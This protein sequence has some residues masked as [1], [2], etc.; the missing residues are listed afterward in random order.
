MD[1]AFTVRELVTMGRTP[2][3]GRFR[4]E[5]PEDLAAVERA[6]A[7]TET[8][9][10]ADRAVDELSGGERQ[11]AHLARALAQETKVLLLDEPTA[12]LDIEHQLGLLTLVRGLVREGRA[13][14]LAIHDLQMA[15]R[16]A[17]RVLLLAGGAI[18]ASGPPAEVFTEARLAEWFRIRARVRNAEDGSLEL[19]PVAPLSPREK[20]PGPML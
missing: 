9:A 17:D 18:V 16:F 3:V 14:L 11:R 19:I 1:F 7:A 5:G 20:Q 15:A 8:A 12:S 4:P 2:H 10:F 6:L 13:A